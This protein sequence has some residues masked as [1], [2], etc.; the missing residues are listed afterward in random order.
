V[1]VSVVVLA[2]NAEESV[3]EVLP[4]VRKALGESAEIILVDGHSVD[5]TVERA[6]ASDE[7]LVVIQQYGKGK[8]WA[9]R[10]AMEKF[11]GEIFVTI[12]ADNT[13]DPAEIPSAIKPIINGKVDVILGSRFKGWIKEGAMSLTHY[14]G[15]KF[16]SSLV[17]LRCLKRISD[18]LTGLRAARKEVI[19]DLSLSSVG[20]DVEA[21]MTVKLVKQGLEVVEVP[22]TYSRRLGRSKLSFRDSWCILKRILMVR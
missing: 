4:K 14:L 3:G 17:S 11:T 7:K 5:K 21:E 19:R 8:G 10:T 22:I 20:F 1:K 18:P 16:F 12:D 2:M 13:Y 9:I 15:N 6:K